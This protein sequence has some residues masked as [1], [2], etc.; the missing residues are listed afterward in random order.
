M[1][2]YSEIVHAPI[3]IVWEHFVQKIEHPENFVPGV[4]NVQIPDKNETR[5]IREMDIAAPDGS[6]ARVK[7]EITHAPYWVKF[8]IL[9]HPTFTGHVDNLA[10]TISD[11]ETR[12]T[13]TLN[14]V[15]KHNGEV[16]SN[17][18]IVK[19]AVKKTIEF[20]SAHA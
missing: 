20:I 15:N 7:E 8:L 13:F 14:W 6:K 17:P 10:E 1:I 18:D 16:F 11:H 12:I 19:N 5:V 9:D 4:S 3:D 2:T